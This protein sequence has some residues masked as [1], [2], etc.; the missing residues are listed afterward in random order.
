M[1]ELLVAPISRASILLANVVAVIAVTALQLLV[2]I[3]VSALRG[4][5]YQTTS[6]MLWSSPPP[7]CSWS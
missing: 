4:A 5:Q 6:R 1:R 7:C 2:L 3:A